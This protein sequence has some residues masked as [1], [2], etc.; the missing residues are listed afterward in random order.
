ML[1]SYSFLRFINVVLLGLMSS[2]FSDI[3]ID[4]GIEKQPL[5]SAMS[6]NTA[7]PSAFKIIDVLP[8]IA[9]YSSSRFA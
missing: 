6:N 2:L 4:K 3:E 1:V 7:L 8:G 5:P 9:N